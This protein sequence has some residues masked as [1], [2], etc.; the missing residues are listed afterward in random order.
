MDLWNN[1]SQFTINY[2]MLEKSRLSLDDRWDR[3]QPPRDT[4]DGLDG[5]E[6]GWM[7]VGKVHKCT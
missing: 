3:L 6:N 1:V 2:Y 4:T 5:I 7:D